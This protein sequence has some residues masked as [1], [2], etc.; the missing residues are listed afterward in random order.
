M[1]SIAVEEMIERASRALIG[2]ASAPA[3][4]IL[5]GSHARGDADEGSDFDFLVI[6][7]EVEDRLA[8]AVRLRDALRGFGAPVDVIVMDEALVQRRA[9][10]KGTMVDRALR[11]GRV[12]A[13]S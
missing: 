7:R 2:A 8:E 6:E 5:F 9:K 1:S 10:V 11:E 4:V 12:V 3:K 13:E